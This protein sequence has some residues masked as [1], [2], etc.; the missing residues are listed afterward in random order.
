MNLAASEMSR[1]NLDS[2]T[3]V[4]NLVASL[5]RVC[6]RVHYWG[7]VQG[8]GFRASAKYVASNYD[9]TG[10]VRNLPDGQVELLACGET[11]EVERFLADLAERM[12]D[13]VRGHRIDDEPIQ[14][15]NSFEIRI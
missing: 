13:Y 15:F 9:V 11:G 10:Y 14:D 4:I 3:I 5:M 8:V 7:R 2:N 1:A 12:A 6:K